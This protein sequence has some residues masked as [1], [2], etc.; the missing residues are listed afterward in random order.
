MVYSYQGCLLTRVSPATISDDGATTCT[1]A[2]REPGLE[3]GGVGFGASE[4]GDVVVNPM[5]LPFGDVFF[6]PH[7]N[8]GDG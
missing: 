5:K 1:G 8:T 4:D 2:T 6:P 3:G 7:G